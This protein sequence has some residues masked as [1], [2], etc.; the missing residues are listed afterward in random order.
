[1]G[2]LSSPMRVSRHRPLLLVRKP[3]G[4]RRPEPV[5]SR[6]LED[7]PSGLEPAGPSLALLRRP[8][9]VPLGEGLKLWV[10]G[11]GGDPD[12]ATPCPLRRGCAQ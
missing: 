2:F 12:F 6:G 11:C 5:G 9:W 8:V 3:R 4:A 1:M 10:G 7:G